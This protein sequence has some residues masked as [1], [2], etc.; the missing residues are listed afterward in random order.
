MNMFVSA[1][2]RTEQQDL[3]R[4]HNSKLLHLCLSEWDKTLHTGCPR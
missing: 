1:C 2:T 4:L 3:P